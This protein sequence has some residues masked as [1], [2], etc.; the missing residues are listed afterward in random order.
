M[1]PLVRDVMRHI[2]H[3]AKTA[4]IT[5]ADVTTLRQLERWREGERF[6]VVINEQPLDIDVDIYASREDIQADALA[7]LERLGWL[8]VEQVGQFRVRKKPQVLP[9]LGPEGK[10]L[11]PYLHGPYQTHLGRYTPASRIRAQLAFDERL[12]EP[13]RTRHLIS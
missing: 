4:T 1:K 11:L 2:V 8:G 5:D 13:H 12:S 7:T 9:Y 6:N 10:G 3:H